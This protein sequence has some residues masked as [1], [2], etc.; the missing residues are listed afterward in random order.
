MSDTPPKKVI[1]RPF[2]KGQVANPGGRPK[3]YYAMLK[4]ARATSPEALE[5]IVGIMRN[6]RRRSPKL[7]LKAAEI[8]LD[9]AWGRVPHAIAGGEGG[10]G[11]IKM[12]VC[13]KGAAAATI[14]ITPNEPP[15]LEVSDVE[16]DEEGDED[17]S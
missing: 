5:T 9:R 1:G 3:S 11:P 6:C 4:A 10:E 12:E 16:D 17:G 7:A 2:K 8:I 14:D 15:L 13:W